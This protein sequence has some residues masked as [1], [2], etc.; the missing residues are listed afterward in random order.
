MECTCISNQQCNAVS[1]LALPYRVRN[2]IAGP[3]KPVNV[4]H[5]EVAIVVEFSTKSAL[6]T[7]F[8]YFGHAQKPDAG[9]QPAQS[10]TQPCP[11]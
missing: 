4:A 1:T 8:E 3:D 2:A 9:P 5:R 11:V 7:S 10:S 6:K